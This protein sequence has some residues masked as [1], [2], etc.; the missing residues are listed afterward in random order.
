MEEPDPF[1]LGSRASEDTVTADQDDLT[2]ELGNGI[3][4]GS[5]T[6]S[7]KPAT[8]KPDPA[9]LLNPKAPK[10]P[11]PDEDT[12]DSDDVSF[13]GM[14]SMIERLHRAE[15]R[16]DAPPKRRKLESVNDNEDKEAA[17]EQEQQEN[18]AQ[19]TGAAKGGAVSEF[20]DEQRKEQAKSNDNTTVIDLTADDDVQIT[21]VNEQSIC[22][23]MIQDA[24]VHAHLIP[25]PRMG[26]FQGTSRAW[27][28]MKVR[29]R[30]PPDQKSSY[31]IEVV[32]PSLRS[33]GKV[34]FITSRALAPL[35]DSI[36]L[37][38]LRVDSRLGVR[39]KEAGETPGAPISTSM[40]LMLF[41]YA[42]RRKAVS[43]GKFLTQWSVVLANPNPQLVD[44]GYNVWNPHAPEKERAKLPAV[45]AST[46]EYGSRSGI[47]SRTAEE[48]RVEV[49]DM[50]DSLIKTD[51]LPEKEQD[52]QIT[53]PLLSH[54]KQALYFMT[55]REKG[56]GIKE[57]QSEGYSL[58]RSKYRPNGQM[59]Y[60]NVITG[61]ETPH[62]PPPVWGGILADMM[63][64]G[65]TLSI[66]SL[67]VESLDDAKRFETFVPPRTPARLLKTN[68]KAT[69]LVCPLST[70]ANW[71]EQIKL[72]IKPGTINYY[73]YHGQSRTDDVVKLKGYDMVITSYQTLA[74][75]FRRAGS[76]SPLLDGQ[77]YRIVL[78]EAHIIRSRETGQSQAACEVFAERR[79]A[80]TGT[81]IQNSLEDLGSLLKFLKIKPFDEKNAF[82][83][84]IIR[85]FKE[86]DTEILPKLRLLVDHITLRR[87][88]DRINLPGRV[89][90]IVRLDFSGPEHALYEFFVK[91]SA[92]KM[93]QLTSAGKA[94]GGRTYA[95]VL[96]AIMRIR[97]I[98]AHGR[99]LL[100]D[101]DLK[102]AQGLT[103]DD[104]IEIGD[105]EEELPALTQRQAFEM[106][107]LLRESEL[108]ICSSCNKRI[109]RTTLPAG[110]ADDSSEDDKD[111]DTI[112]Y[113]TACYHLICP[114]CL[115]EFQD[116]MVPNSDPTN[117]FICHL[118]NQYV[119]ICFF[120]MKQ[121][122]LDEDERA[123]ARVR[124]NPRLAK[125]LGRYGGPHTK[126]KTL[127]EKLKEYETWS[128][129]L[130]NLLSIAIP[131]FLTCVG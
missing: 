16:E 91:D 88:K 50:F 24:K 40:P 57:D 3:T 122:E 55:E 44:R 71:E 5:A 74:A 6:G 12:E 26:Q 23:G 107:Y 19:F 115:D 94:M 87:L 41:L 52:E 64:L 85:P 129:V 90:N 110:I 45:L 98:C 102:M 112:G 63:G 1:I 84:H 70:L 62:R 92:K 113:M 51:D 31:I 9:L 37:N 65:K 58:W 18:K 114:G 14:G 43:I 68:L 60:Y 120:E 106:Y 80:V 82:G 123:K 13:M 73:M 108:H 22:M 59:I 128:E 95:H 2:M 86:A 116:K 83:N 8:G 27:P 124:A 96:K 34:D 21:N 46:S 105:E 77:F 38:N 104:A 97:L 103:A 75:D 126:A 32:D 11:R 78:D 28:A 131:G 72:H 125:Q 79:W 47:G 10:R 15:R 17:D 76:K 111:N 118:C 33:F 29:L 39:K 66:L 36:H 89:D 69:L 20:M 25:T 119:K 61:H 56:T 121:S 54:Q 109:G 42:P 49:T 67:I 99:E 53:T 4:N 101:E 7:P 130:R 100:N 48:I 93:Q 117:H 35:L 30:R 81:P 127:M